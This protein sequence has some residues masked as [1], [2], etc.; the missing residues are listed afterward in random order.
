MK[1]LLFGYSSLAIR[2][3][4][5]A[6]EKLDFISSFDCASLSKNIPTNFYKKLDGIYNSYEIAIKNSDADFVYISTANFKHSELIKLSLNHNKNIIVDKPAV[7]YLDDAKRL[8]D[9]ANKKKKI[10]IEA[11]TYKFHP[12]IDYIKK[13]S[14][15]INQITVN[16]S[17]PGFEITNF[18]Y[19]NELGGGVVY[20]MAPY[21]IDIGKTIFKSNPIYFYGKLIKNNVYSRMNIIIEFEKNKMVSG[22]F[23]FES[24]YVNNGFFLGKDIL[25]SSDRLFTSDSTKNSTI[26]MRTKNISKDINFDP[27]DSFINFF[28]NLLKLNK[29]DFKKINSVFLQQATDMSNFIKEINK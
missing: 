9:L 21:A 12:Q 10:I 24:E 18:R 28:K 25:L 26:L 6:L 11:I 23:G 13:Y 1:I 20:D 4:I 5:P 22:F 7:L 27:S 15:Q 14:N 19:Y 3:I 2:K 17:I 29:K 16:F 8:F